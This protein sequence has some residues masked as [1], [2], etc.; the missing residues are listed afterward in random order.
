M[1]AS[2]FIRR[3]PAGRDI[4][5]FACLVRCIRR[6]SKSMSSSGRE[7]GRRHR[8]MA[9]D[10]RPLTT[11][12]PPA[13]ERL[14]MGSRSDDRQPRGELNLARNWCALATDFDGT[15]ATDGVIDEP[16]IEAL[17]RFRHGGAKLILVTGRELE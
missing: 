9:S 16:T 6:F 10:T 17:Q 3:A 11:P 7:L 15:V 1:G 5:G 13:G 8:T 4:L 2:P 12:A 14:T